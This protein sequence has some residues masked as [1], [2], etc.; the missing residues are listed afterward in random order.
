M[1]PKNYNSNDNRKGGR[2]WNTEHDC[3]KKTNI[4]PMYLR[5][6]LVHLAQPP[7]PSLCA[8]YTWLGNIGFIPQRF[9]LLGLIPLLSGGQKT[10]GP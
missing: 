9:L 1:T 7:A 2:Q 3:P 5:F 8:T 10:G 4:F 6:S